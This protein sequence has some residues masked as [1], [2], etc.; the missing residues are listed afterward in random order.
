MKWLSDNRLNHLRELTVNPDFTAT[1]Y[2]V[3]TALAR[4]GMGTIY[5]ADDTELNRQIGRAHV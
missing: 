5:L 3:T 4:G 1:K 2:R